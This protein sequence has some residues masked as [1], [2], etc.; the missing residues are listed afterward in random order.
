[1]FYI[2]SISNTY[3]SVLKIEKFIVCEL[4]GDCIVEISRMVMQ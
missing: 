2:L 1:M 3:S 4:D